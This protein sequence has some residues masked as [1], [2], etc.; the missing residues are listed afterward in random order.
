MWDVEDILSVGD[1]YCSSVRRP[2]KARGTH[3]RYI[4]HS[5]YSG[6]TAR[7]QSATHVPPF[8]ALS[9]EKMTKV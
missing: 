6:Y 8:F 3:S 1:A 9:T 4:A 2:G 5:R 7:R